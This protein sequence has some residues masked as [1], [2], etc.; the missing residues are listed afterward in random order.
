M[1]ALTTAAFYGTDGHARQTR[2]SSGG[3]GVEL[4]QVCVIVTINRENAIERVT[5]STEHVSMQGKST[6]EH[7]M[8][9]A[10]K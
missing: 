2:H 10:L 8:S 6:A 3:G 1:V 5:G 9:A 4:E 7:E